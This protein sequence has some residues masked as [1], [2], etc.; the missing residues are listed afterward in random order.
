MSKLRVLVI[1]SLSNPLG[2]NWVYGLKGLGYSVVVLDYRKFPATLQQLRIWG[3]NEDIPLFNFWQTVSPGLHQSILN[4]LGGKPEVLFGW[5]GSPILEP[6]KE[7]HQ[8]FPEAKT[9]VCVDTLPNASNL[10]TEIRE[11][12]RFWQANSFINGYIF[13][14]QK[15]AELFW[16]RTP[17]AKKKPYLNLIEPFLKNAFAKD[18]EENINIP[19]LE[20]FD[21]SPHIIFTGR[22]DKLWSQD[23]RSKKDAVGLFLGQIAERGVHVFILE[24]GDTKGIP[25]L[26]LYPEFSN[27]ELFTGKFAQYI[28]QFDAQLVIYNES[29]GTFRRRTATG[30][31]TR[32]AFAMTATSPVVVTTNSK[33]VEEYWGDTPFGFTF[34]N[35]DDLVASLGDR[36]LLTLLRQNMKKVHLSYAFE[37]QANRLIDF[38]QKLF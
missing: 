6:L 33:F 34:E 30:L 37:S 4:A 31:S 26:H 27:A 23:F 9:V 25:N 7:I 35:V 28:S 32:L 19:K 8:C 24:V 16:K 10:L 18:E 14:S 20:R 11:I 2:T 12:T 1:A 13:Y 5:W 36:E 3:V 17:A 21:N 15:M 38:F 22:A 29:N